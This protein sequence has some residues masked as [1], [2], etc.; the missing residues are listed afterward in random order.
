MPSVHFYHAGDKVEDFVCGPKKIPVLKE[1]LED[2]VNNGIA[3]A[4]SY[5]ELLN[6]AELADTTDITT[7][8]DGSVVKGNSGGSS[9]SGAQGSESSGGITTDS[10]SQLK[11]APTADGRSPQTSQ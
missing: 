7:M 2:Y 1:R 8:Y 11:D 6:A 10:W 9:G 4:M 5:S 3:A